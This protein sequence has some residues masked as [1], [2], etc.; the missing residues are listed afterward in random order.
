[1]VWQFFKTARSAFPAV[2]LAPVGPDRE[3]EKT[4]LEWRDSRSR[5][6]LFSEDPRSPPWAGQERASGSATTVAPPQRTFSQT[7]RWR[8]HVQLGKPRQK[9]GGVGRAKV[10]GCR[11]G[12]TLSAAPG[13]ASSSVSATRSWSPCA[14]CWKRLQILWTSIRSVAADTVNGPCRLPE[15]SLS[16]GGCP[17]PSATLGSEVSSRRYPTERKELRGT[18][19][20]PDLSLTR[21]SSRHSDRPRSSTAPAAPRTRWPST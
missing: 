17:S 15:G 14:S 11:R 2:V 21:R 9:S 19:H 10:G 18:S 7:A 8:L 4:A 20:R 3:S 1:M 16:G 13:S 5:Y 6:C 12:P